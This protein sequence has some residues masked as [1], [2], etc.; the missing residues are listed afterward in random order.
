MKAMRSQE[1]AAFRIDL[2]LRLNSGLL[3]DFFE[4]RQLF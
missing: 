3:I 2:G 4:L 1:V